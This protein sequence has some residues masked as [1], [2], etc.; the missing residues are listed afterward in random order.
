[1]S[2]RQH[3]GLAD[4]LRAFGEGERAQSATKVWRGGVQTLSVMVDVPLLRWLGLL[5][6]CLTLA[7]AALVAFA[8]CVGTGREEPT[9]K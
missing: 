8:R 6:W 3:A 1:M 9:G 7:D 5:T 4:I 2:A